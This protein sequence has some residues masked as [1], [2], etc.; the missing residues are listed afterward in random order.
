MIYARL[1]KILS[2]WGLASRREAETMIIDGRVRINGTIATLGQTANPQTDRIEIDGVEIKPQNRPQSI[3]LLLNKPLGVISSCSDPQN[4][5]TVLDL[6]PPSLTQNTGIH[7]VGRLD[8]NSTGAIL[9][10][11]DGELTNYLI[12]PRHHIAKTYHVWVKDNPPEYIL[13][14]WRDGVLLLGKKTKPASVTKLT[15]TNQKSMLEIVLT[16]GRNRQIRMIA[17]QLGYPVIS[18]HRIAIADIGLEKLPLGSYRHLKTWE[19]SCLK[20]TITSI[21]QL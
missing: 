11:N 4:R 2:Q 5:P 21:K 17:A 8:I 13:Q 7:P 6:L 14:K 12:H 20:N 3:Y 10:T 19:I 1:Q 18:L 15:Q 9:L 16:E